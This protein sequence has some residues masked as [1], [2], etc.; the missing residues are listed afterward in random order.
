MPIHVCFKFDIIAAYIIYNIPII[1]RY[2]LTDKSCVI[3][4]DDQRK[5]K[6]PKHGLFILFLRSSSSKPVLSS[7]LKRPKLVFNTDYRFKQC[8]SKVLQ[9]APRGHSSILSTFIK[10]PYSI[11]TF[12]LS[13]LK[14]PLKTGFTVVKLSINETAQ[15]GMV[16]YTIY[17]TEYFIPANWARFIELSTSIKYTFCLLLPSITLPAIRVKLLL[18]I[19]I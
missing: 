8:R 12:A 18:P 19:C 6:K 4:M 2:I 16:H 1:L 17:V 14:W 7:H 11:K 10:L 13:I 3:S 15:D 5:H 9:N